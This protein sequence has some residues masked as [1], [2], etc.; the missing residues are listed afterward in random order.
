MLPDKPDV[1][2]QFLH[3]WSA[4]IMMYEPVF[5]FAQQLKHPACNIRDFAQVTTTI[6]ICIDKRYKL[7]G[8][9]ILAFI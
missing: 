1:V 8:G 9:I 3:E 7:Q 4:I 6:N 5:L 2:K